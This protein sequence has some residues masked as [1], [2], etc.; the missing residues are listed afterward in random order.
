MEDKD[1]GWRRLK[2]IQLTSAKKNGK[3]KWWQLEEDTELKLAEELKLSIAQ[4]VDCMNDIFG[5][6][7]RRYT[8]SSIENRRRRMS[9]GKSRPSTVQ[10]QDLI[11]DCKKSLKKVEQSLVYYSNSHSI[12]VKCNQC[13]HEWVKQAKN[14]T[15]ECRVCNRVGGLPTGPEPALV[16]LLA[17]PEWDKC[18]P[19]YTKIGNSLSPEEAI[20]KTSKKRNYPYP[21]TIVAYDLS[22]KTEAGILEDRLLKDTIHSRS[23]IETQEFDGHTEFRNIK[24]LKQLLPEYKTVLDTAFRI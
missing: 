18:K 10:N 11:L 17:F 24:V 2:H 14:C 1:S 22:T 19:G 15:Q 20:H 3:A 6:K 7:Y 12:L 16:Y 8:K 21:Y 4:T 9:L 23:F 13:D 5:T